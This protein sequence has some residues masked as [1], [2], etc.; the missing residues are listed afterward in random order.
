M[1]TVYLG[2][3]TNLGN[4]EQNLHF[5][6]EQIQKRIGDV[7]TLSAFYMTEPWGFQSTNSFLNAACAVQTN[8]TPEELLLVTQSIEKQIGRKEKS[9]NRI[10]SDRLIDID[11]LL[12]D[13]V[14]VNSKELVIPHPLM[15]QRRFVLE[16]LV[17]IAPDVIHPILKEPIRTL[18]SEK[19]ILL[20]SYHH[21]LS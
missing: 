19:E 17:E 16:P 20:E 13:E 6:V 18:F 10:Y 9:I 7:I 1:A 15:E 2:L 4:R 21:A 12:Y 11:I 5:A 3:G 14:I 8:Y